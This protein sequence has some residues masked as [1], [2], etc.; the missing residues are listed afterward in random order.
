MR[1]CVV[2]IGRANASCNII[3][4]NHVTVTNPA[5]SSKTAAVIT[6]SSAEEEEIDDGQRWHGETPDSDCKVTRDAPG[7]HNNNI[8]LNITK[9]FAHE[10]EQ[11]FHSF[12]Y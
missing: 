8:K 2:P 11:N 7:Q 9:Y 6:C 12:L 4:L 3:T 5:D 1:A 10:T